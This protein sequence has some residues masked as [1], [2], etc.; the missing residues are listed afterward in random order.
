MAGAGAA[1]GGTS[2]GG[3]AGSGGG[4]GAA[5]AAGSAGADGGSCEPVKAFCGTKPSDLLECCKPLECAF[6]PSD[7]KYY[8]CKSANQP[9][10]GD[11]E[12]CKG[13]FCKAAA[14]G[15]TCQK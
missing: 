9:C 2:S 10:G 14:S 4:A 5:G 15:M 7:F 8:C 12:C 11:T 3:S 1:S 13:L 6:D